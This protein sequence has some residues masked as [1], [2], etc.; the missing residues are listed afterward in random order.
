[1]VFEYHIFHIREPLLYRRRLRDDIHAVGIFLYHVMKP[2]DLPFQYLEPADNPFGSG[3]VC[4]SHIRSSIYPPGGIV[5]LPIFMPS[6][7]GIE[8]RSPFRRPVAIRRRISKEAQREG[9]A[10][11]GRERCRWGRRT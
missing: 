10:P 11:R 5:K 6:A 7:R 1:M 2:P 8:N 3:T 9:S 4:V